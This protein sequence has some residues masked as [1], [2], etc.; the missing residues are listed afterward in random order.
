M[1]STFWLLIVNVNS[2]CYVHPP[3]HSR[4]S[5]YTHIY[6]IWLWSDSVLW[7]YTLCLQNVFWF[8]ERKECTTLKCS[9]SLESKC[10]MSFPTQSVDCKL[11]R[12]LTTRL[13]ITLI[14][15]P[16]NFLT[17]RNSLWGQGK[18]TKSSSLFQ[19]A[20]TSHEIY[21]SHFTQNAL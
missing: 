10:L 13:K 21:H 12:K 3:T 1:L 16:Q 14:L 15:L 8:L 2:A 9:W 20:Q 5:T 4:A 6:T 7:Y 19:S 17:L 18:N 11:E